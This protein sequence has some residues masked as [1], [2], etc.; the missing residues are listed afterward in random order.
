MESV[1][2][3]REE[4]AKAEDPQDRE[5]TAEKLQRE[6]SALGRVEVAQERDETCLIRTRMQA[7]SND[8]TRKYLD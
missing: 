6:A 7:R 3:T 4:L 2:E 5:R 8:R 1:E